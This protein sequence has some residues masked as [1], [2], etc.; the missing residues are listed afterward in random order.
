M[1][2]DAVF[3]INLSGQSLSDDDILEFIDEE[4]QAKQASRPKSGCVLRITESA[5]V[6]NLAKA[7]Q[8]INEL[9]KRGCGISLDDFGAGL[10]SFAYLKNFNVD[11]L[12]ID[13]SFIRDITDNRISESM[14]AAITQVAKVMELQ[15]RGRVCRERRNPQAHHVSWV[16]TLR[17]VM[18]D[19]QTTAFGRRHAGE[20]V[21]RL[22][23]V[24]G[25]LKRTGICWRV[26]ARCGSIDS[27]AWPRLHQRLPGILPSFRTSCRNRYCSGSTRL[28][29]GG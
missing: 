26:I 14:V 29:A 1:S 28:Q 10:S 24:F 8:F 4:L 19:R 7:Q 12:K 13:G 17:K 15:Y 21:R 5:A 25:R 9:R 11:A 23:P 3:S 20:F 27:S 22:Q 2:K 18:R 16:S 6:S